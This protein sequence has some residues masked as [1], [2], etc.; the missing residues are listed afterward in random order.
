MGGWGGKRTLVSPLFISPQGNHFVG[1]TCEEEEGIPLRRKKMRKTKHF[2]C[3]N[4]LS[5]LN[6]VFSLLG[7]LF[8]MSKG[9][10]S[11]QE[12]VFNSNVL[13]RERESPIIGSTPLMKVLNLVRPDAG[14]LHL[15]WC[16]CA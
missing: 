11:G 13:T 14:P 6:F 4:L 12:I 9:A 5:S 15:Y 1:K 3:V 16:C 2:Y 7:L 8:S 10:F